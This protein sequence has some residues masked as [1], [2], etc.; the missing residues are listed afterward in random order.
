MKLPGFLWAYQPCSL[1]HPWTS[2]RGLGLNPA[3]TFTIEVLVAQSCPTLCNAMDCNPQ[4]NPCP[5]GSPGKN[6]GVGCQALLQGIFPTQGS[7]PGLLH[8]RDGLFII[9]ATREA[10]VNLD[11]ELRGN[12]FPMVLMTNYH[13]LSSWKQHEF[14]ILDFWR[15]EVQMDITGLKLR[16]WQSDSFWEFQRIN[17]IFAVSAF[18]S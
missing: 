7:N 3:S 11:E 4:D 15:P 5:W 12:Q 10:T 2:L 16:C 18:Q 14:I 17:L 13:T 1:V 6:T 8:C 9:W